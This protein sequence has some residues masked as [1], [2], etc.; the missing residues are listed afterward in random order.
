MIDDF[1]DNSVM[2]EQ[3]QALL[4]L[5][6]TVEQMISDKDEVALQTMEIVPSPDFFDICNKLP[7]SRIINVM[8]S[9]MPTDIVMKISQK[10]S[11]ESVVVGRKFLFFIEIP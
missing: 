11:A 9:V 8:T 3:R 2:M 1:P 4:D 10:S 6:K 5:D 7:P